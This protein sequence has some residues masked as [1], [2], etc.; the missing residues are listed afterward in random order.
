MGNFFDRALEYV[1]RGW[2]VFPVCW[3]NASGSC[4]CGRG[5]E[6][7]GKAPLA[8]GGYKSASMDLD[9]LEEWDRRWPDANIGIALGVSGL[10]VIDLDGDA[11]VAE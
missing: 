10:F 8:D 4:G 9:R 2:F 6:K 5:H 1:G 3:P 7:G 11:A